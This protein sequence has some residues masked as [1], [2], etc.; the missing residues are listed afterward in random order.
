MIQ[1]QW[2]HMFSNKELQILISGAEIPVDIDDLKRHTKYSGG[3]HENHPTI[4]L[5]WQVVE[6]FNDE[7]RRS[8]LKF[9]TSCSRQPLFGFKV[10]S[11]HFSVAFVTSFIYLCFNFRNWIHHFV[12]KKPVQRIAYLQLVLA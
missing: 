5:F 10:F 1:P 3:Y 11:S 7:Q 9:V 12:F 2:L 6:E 4:K 8:L